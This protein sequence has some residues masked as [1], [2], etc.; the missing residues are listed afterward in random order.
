MQGQTRLTM[1][2][3]GVPV[4]QGLSLGHQELSKALGAIL[5]AFG[6]NPSRFRLP[7]GR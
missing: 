6:D 2:F 3:K 5:W 7:P 1:L 4:C